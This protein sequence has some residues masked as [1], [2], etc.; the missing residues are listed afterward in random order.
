MA[1]TI[2]DINKITTEVWGQFILEQ[3]LNQDEIPREKEIVSPIQ[4]S[5]E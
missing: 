5:D 3:F 2:E 4:Y 1:T